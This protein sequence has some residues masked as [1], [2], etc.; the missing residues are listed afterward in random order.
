M[1]SN[2]QQLKELLEVT[3]YASDILDK[4]ENEIIDLSNEKEENESRIDDLEKELAEVPD[5]SFEIIDFG[6][7]E[8]KYLQPDNLR[9]AQFMDSLKQRFHGHTLE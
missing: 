5:Y 2:I 4:V 7:G 6:V 1:K 9:V 8:L 3:V